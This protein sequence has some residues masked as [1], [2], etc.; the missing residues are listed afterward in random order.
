MENLKYKRDPRPEVDEQALAILREARK[1]AKESD[2]LGRL[3]L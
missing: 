2:R 1:L 3:A